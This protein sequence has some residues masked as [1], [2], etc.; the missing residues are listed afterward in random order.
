LIVR[1]GTGAVVQDLDGDGYEGTGWVVFYMHVESR[2]R[3][4]P[5]TFVKA[6]ERIGH[7]SCEGGFS[8]GT[9]LH[10]ARRYNGEWI[11]ADRD[12]PFVLDTW[13]SQGGGGEY[14]GFL[15]QE[16]RVIEAFAGRTPENTL[17]R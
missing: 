14:N 4:Q 1:T 8:T 10:L 3:V 13:V 16:G 6:G 7:P 15:V 11:S 9:H 5:G 2:D 17:Q 12:L